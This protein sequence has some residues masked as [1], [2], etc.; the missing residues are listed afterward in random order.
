MESWQENFRIIISSGVCAKSAEHYSQMEYEHNFVENF[1]RFYCITLYFYCLNILLYKLLYY[2]YNM[3]FFAM[4]F[5]FFSNGL[6][7]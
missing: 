3:L 5:F 2:V 4:F 1:K 6:Q 7:C